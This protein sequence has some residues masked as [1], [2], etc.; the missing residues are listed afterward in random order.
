[1]VITSISS[2]AP[3]SSSPAAAG[4]MALVNQKM[5]G[6]PQG[7]ANYV[8]YRLAKVSGVYHD[9]VKGNNKVPDPNGQYTVGYNA[10]KGYDLATGLGSMDVNALVNN[11]KAAS[12]GAGSS[13]NSRTWQRTERD[14]S[15]WKADYFPGNRRP[16]LAPEPAPLPPEP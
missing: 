15:P 7:M 14:R 1:M 2:V 9:T 6:Q 5:G 10:G 4:I 12:S 11:W 16:V 13:D 3:Q 8:F